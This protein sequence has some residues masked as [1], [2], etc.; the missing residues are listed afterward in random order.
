MQT[1]KLRSPVT[2]HKTILPFPLEIYDSKKQET[3]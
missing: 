3:N 1:V 2:R